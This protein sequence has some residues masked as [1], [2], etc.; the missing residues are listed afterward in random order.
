MRLLFDL[1]YIDE[2]D[3]YNLEYSLLS[4]IINDFE[5]TVLLKKKDEDTYI[6][7][8]IKSLNVLVDYVYGQTKRKK[9]KEIDEKLN[10]NFDYALFPYS[11]FEHIFKKNPNT[12]MIFAVNDLFKMLQSRP[13]K[14]NRYDFRFAKSKKDLFILLLMKVVRSTGIYYNYLHYILRKNIENAY[15][16]TVPSKYIESILKKEFLIQNPNKVRMVHP[17]YKLSKEVT[18]TKDDKNFILLLEGDKYYNNTDRVI[19]VLDKLYGSNRLKVR[20]Y[21]LGNPAKHM[22]KLAKNQEYFTYF[23]NLSIEDANYYF[24]NANLVIVPSLISNCELQ[25]LDA[26]K[27]GTNVICSNIDSL[28]EMYSLLD[29]FNPYDKRDIEE[30]I[31]SNVNKNQNEAF[32]NLYEYRI[33]IAALE[34]KEIMKELKEK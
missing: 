32:I 15:E 10:L 14:I 16:I 3:N 8:K 7:K 24:K 5:V 11:P 31:L 2:F 12:K 13:N 22:M 1:T 28:K 23:D 18:S 29:M 34:H 27:F 20:T 9:Y 6:D 33:N 21:V 30:K 25:I 19:K 17:M 26:L 4:E